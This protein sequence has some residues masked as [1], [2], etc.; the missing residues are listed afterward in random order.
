[1]LL[2]ISVAEQ[3]LDIPAPALLAAEAAEV[4]L[5]AV[6]MEHLASLYLRFA[7]QSPQ[8]ASRSRR[9]APR[10]TEDAGLGDSLSSSFSSSE[11]SLTSSLLS[12]ACPA[13]AP[14]PDNDGHSQPPTPHKP[15]PDPQQQQER[16]V[17]PVSPEKPPRLLLSHGR[18]HESLLSPGPASLQRPDRRQSEAFTAALRK[19]SSLSSSHISIKLPAFSLPSKPPPAQ[20]PEARDEVTAGR[21]LSSSRP[22]ATETKETI[23][24]QTECLELHGLQRLAA[25]CEASDQWHSSHLGPGWPQHY[26]STQLS[27]C[28]Q[29]YSTLV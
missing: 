7:D 18:S 23:S 28:Y 14:A 20:R 27:P 15:P 10:R 19:F 13:P 22:E 11:T 2:A 8:P 25:S 16:R 26:Y 9:A 21:G 3:H 6:M 24:T 17:S 5:E 12:P 4:E 29:M 1:M